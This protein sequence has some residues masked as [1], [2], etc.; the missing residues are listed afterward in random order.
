MALKI[1]WQYLFENQSYF[2][3]L[4][5]THYPFTEN[6]LLVYHPIISIGSP[7]YYLYDDI[8]SQTVFGLIFND[9]V[10]WTEKLQELYYEKPQLIYAADSDIYSFELKFNNLPLSINL[11][12]ENTRSINQD[13][14]ISGYGYSDEE[15][16]YDNLNDELNNSDKCFDEILTK[17]EF[18]NLELDSIVTKENNIY[19]AN[20]K[21]YQ[22]FINCICNDMPDF[23]IPR[24]YEK[25]KIEQ[26]K[27]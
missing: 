7:I 24:F 2:N 27:T 9:K 12:L 16:Y 11:E 19:I 26:I 23:S 15:G 5:A 13:Q 21:F 18:S 20:Y 6:E 22:T 10:Q 14:I 25:L 4:F 3:Q 17:F 8:F 1:N